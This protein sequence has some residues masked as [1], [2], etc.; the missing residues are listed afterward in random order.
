M[1]PWVRD[2]DWPQEDLPYHYILYLH[3]GRLPEELIKGR[4]ALMFLSLT[5]TFTGAIMDLP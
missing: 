5:D 4:P 1:N 3:Y 2:W